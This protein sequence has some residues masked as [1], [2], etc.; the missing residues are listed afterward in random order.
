[1]KNH[2]ALKLNEANVARDRRQEVGQFFAKFEEGAISSLTLRIARSWIN[3]LE[4]CRRRLSAPAGRARLRMRGDQHLDV[5][6]VDGDQLGRFERFGAGRGAVRCSKTEFAE[7][8]ADFCEPQFHPI[9]GLVLANK[10]HLACFRPRTFCR[11]RRP[12][13][14]C[15]VRRESGLLRVLSPVSA[16][17]R[18]QAA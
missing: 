10:L 6:L 14:K 8:I 7:Q 17:Q 15:S 16:I 5:V 18:R 1:M 4:A 11:L 9:I 3:W 13:R 12:L 2:A